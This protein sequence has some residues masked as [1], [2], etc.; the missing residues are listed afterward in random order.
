MV[1]NPAADFYD[2]LGMNLELLP[3]EASVL[4]V[5]SGTSKPTW[6][7]VVASGRKLHG[8]DFFPVMIDLSKKQVPGGTF[9]LVNMIDFAPKE[10]PFDA[11]FAVFSLFHFSREE[12]SIPAEK[13]N[14]WVAPGAYIFIGTMVA[15]DFQPN[16]INSTGTGSRI[17]NLLYSKEGWA[18]LL[19]K[20]GL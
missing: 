11:A 18:E 9:G 6:S 2:H 4:D 5:G 7:I 8:T 3:L 14:T 1:L 16:Q 19:E 13:F 12:M 10:G 15:E 17:G 20:S